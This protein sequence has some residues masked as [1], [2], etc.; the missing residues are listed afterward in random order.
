MEP[1]FDWQYYISIHPDLPAAGIT[2]EKQAINHWI[3]YGKSE[4]R[5]CKKEN[6]VVQKV[7]VQQP[8]PSEN[9]T[10]SEP[11]IQ[12][13]QQ[14]SQQLFQNTNSNKPFEIVVA[15]YKEDLS[16][17][18]QFKDYVKI[19]NKGP[20]DIPSD[21]PKSSIKNLTNVGRE[22]G[23]YVTHIVE[24]YNKLADY[25]MFIQGDP[26]DHCSLNSEE[27]TV[28]SISDTIHEPKTYKF[29]YM[30]I[31]SEPFEKEH[32]VMNGTGIP[33][34]PVEMGEPLEIDILIKEVRDWVKNNCP[35]EVCINPGY[36][37]ENNPGNGIV[38]DLQ[39]WRSLGKS[40]IHPFEFWDLC[41][42]DFWYLTSGSAEKMRQELVMKKFDLSKILPLIEKGYSFNWGAC[43]VVHKSHIQKYPKW[44][45]ERM[46]SCFQVALPGA[47]WGMERLWRF[48]L[49]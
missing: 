8:I 48:V 25:T 35:D 15:R 43:F 13:T 31:H 24:N 45:W 29:K 39:Q 27:F 22:G 23:T 21:F 5:K 3:D 1:D 17:F 14:Q 37:P 34:T 2:T 4:G 42:K 46:N 44:W 10:P 33:C 40:S 7:P 32:L 38:R 16:L 20:D 36:I 28:K 47:G 18:K 30:S 41:Q 12:K 19:Y 11:P 6:V 9:K 49:E 26:I